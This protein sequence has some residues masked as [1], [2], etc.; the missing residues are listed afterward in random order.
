MTEEKY[1][2]RRDLLLKIYKAADK[3]MNRQM[4]LSEFYDLAGKGFSF[5]LT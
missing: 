1:E 4:A 5:F 2:R 3:D